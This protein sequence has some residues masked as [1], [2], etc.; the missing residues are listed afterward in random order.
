MSTNNIKEKTTHR[1]GK[2]VPRDERRLSRN[3]EMES[4]MLFFNTL[5]KKALEKPTQENL[6]ALK[7]SSEKISEMINNSRLS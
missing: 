7:Q 2:Y 3:K 4:Q 6:D 5:S 1:F